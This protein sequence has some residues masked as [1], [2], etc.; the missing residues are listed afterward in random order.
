M[1]HRPRRRLNRALRRR[2]CSASSSRS[3][4]TASG[5]SRRR[6]SI[7]LPARCASLVV[8]RARS[9]HGAGRNRCS[10]PSRA[11]SKG[12]SRAK[13]AS[14]ATAAGAHA[15]AGSGVSPN[16]S[17]IHWARRVS[18]TS[19]K[20]RSCATAC[21]TSSQRD[22]GSPEI[23]SNAIRYIVRISAPMDA[24]NIFVPAGR[25]TTRR[26]FSLLANRATN[27]PAPSYREQLTLMDGRVHIV[28]RRRAVTAKE[29]VEMKKLLAAF[30]FDRGIGFAQFSVGIHIGE[31]P[32]PRVIRVRPNAP[33]PGYSW[34]D[35][36]WY[37]QG[38]RYSWHQGYWTRP[39]YEG[40][41]WSGAAL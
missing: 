3:R 36:Y 25:V 13:R 31:P 6:S 32:R 12:C 29:I 20:F 18:V 16:S 22:A 28:P 5:F 4:A 27:R 41:Q 40:S 30:T 21:A 39:P 26:H 14:T 11:I 37:P 19:S 17:V 1:R 10:A 8:I 24:Q 38:N 34:V 15:R 35:G 23:V 9:T 33:G 7:S 2:F